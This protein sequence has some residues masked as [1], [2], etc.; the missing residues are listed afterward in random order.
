MG[1][2]FPEASQN[3]TL[4]PKSPQ[5]GAEPPKGCPEVAKCHQKRPQID[6]FGAQK[7][8]KWA[9]SFVVSDDLQTAQRLDKNK[10][11]SIPPCFGR[12]FGVRFAGRVGK[13]Q[14]ENEE[15]TTP[16]ANDVSIRDPITRYWVP[17]H[18]RPAMQQRAA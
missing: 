1:V 12:H 18:A 5:M 14:N 7:S 6:D 10:N 2:F 11:V 16:N 15:P 9:E 17:M 3:S 8:L 4:S 13:I